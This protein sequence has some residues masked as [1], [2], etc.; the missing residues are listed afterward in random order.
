MDIL[1]L[2]DN[3]LKQF[4]NDFPDESIKTIYRK[5]PLLAME[6]KGFRIQSMD[7]ERLVNETYRIIKRKK[8]A[9]LIKGLQVLFNKYL[10][11]IKKTEDEFIDKGYPCSIA[12]SLS[13]KKHF[14]DDYLPIYFKLAEVDEI[15]QNKIQDDI[16]LVKI[17]QEI[18][19]K[20]INEI[21]TLEKKDFETQIKEVNKLLKT[22][23][24]EI[25]DKLDFMEN[26]FQEM[27]DGSLKSI[28]IIN[29]TIT[30]LE[31]KQIDCQ[32]KL[33]SL[34]ENQ[35]IL[36]LQSQIKELTSEISALKEHKM[37]TT[38]KLEVIEN[39]VFEQVDNY[40][41]DFIG[42]VIE[43]ITTRETF[44]VFR[45]YLNEVILSKKPLICAEKNTKK[46][47][48]V[49]SS[50]LT[51]GNY[52][53]LELESHTSDS[54]LISK[55]EDI[56]CIGGNKVIV[57]KNKINVSDYYT[58]LKYIRSRPL[59]EKY[60][61]EIIYEKEIQFMPK[62]ILRDFLFFMGDLEKG[63]IEYRYS[64]ALG[65]EKHVNK[66]NTDFLKML[67]ELELKDINVDIVNDKYYGMLSYS[68][69][70]FLS[71]NNDVDINSL[72]NKILDCEIRKK[73]EDVL[74][75]VGR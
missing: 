7:H 32:T 26:K 75:D 1:K 30:K 3:E 55:L 27:L 71:I 50:V 64:Y 41:L 2:S 59:G 63:E 40:L 48:E 73:C 69:I 25:T 8:N 28:N 39:G 45:E 62:E 10:Q 9:T 44:D 37:E 11:L 17:I 65:D 60:I 18:S 43:K 67:E 33:N 51:G 35:S 21:S 5:N 4:I 38:I 46:I 68:L 36:E 42:D 19:K 58:I 57:I 6:I 12:H 22:Q 70:P 53:I 56:D 54:E 47:A 74:N 16:Q 34:N 23:N 66:E 52:F 13:I 72:I 29:G 14:R 49:I 31:D 15:Q 61:F 20:Q 24:L